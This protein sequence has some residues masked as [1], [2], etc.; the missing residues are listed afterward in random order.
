MGKSNPASVQSA[1]A[2]PKSASTSTAIILKPGKESFVRRFHPWIFSGAVASI[3]GRP[4]DG[5]VVQVFDSRK[6]F[7]ATGHFHEGSIAVKLLS[8]QPVELNADFFAQKLT[9]ARR[10]RG[11]LNLT[12]TTAY[13]LV[14]GEGDG[15]PGLVV[16]WYDGVAVLQAHSV[17]MHRQRHQLAEALQAVYGAELKVIFDKSV[18]TLP[19]RYAASVQNGYLVGEAPARPHPIRENG[20]LFLIDWETGQKTGFF[21]DQ[22]ENRAL[23]ARY[24]PGKRVLNAFCYSGGFSIYALAA[25]AELVHSVDASSKA[26][27][28]TNQNVEANFGQ[29]APHE[30]FTDDVQKFL[31]AHGPS[32]GDHPYD[33][34]VLDPPAFAKSLEARHRAVQG[35]KRLNAEGIRRLAPGGILFTFSCSQVVDRELFYNTVVAAALE[36]GRPVRVLHQLSQAPDHPVNA[37]HP[38]GSY[39]KGLVLEVE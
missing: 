31:K 34:I 6:N 10:I 17:G 20:R 4:A 35:Y 21:L 1:I 39:L 28:L 32:H 24:A 12:D 7:L 38:E 3:E 30:A 13:R 33:L 36:A 15:L 9:E 29:T 16:D 14:H 11:L 22:R 37:F 8:W 5:D 18:E 25:G 27:G 26:I 2:N 19:D 23:L